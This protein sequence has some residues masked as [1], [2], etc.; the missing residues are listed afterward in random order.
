MFGTIRK[1]QTWLWAIIITLTIISFVIFFSPYSKLNPGQGPAR[2]G[3]IGGKKVTEEQFIQAQRESMLQ[4]FFMSGGRWPD[5]ESRQMGYDPERETYQWLFLLSK[6]E[7]MNIHIASD[8]VVQVAR[9]MI[10]QFQ[11]AGI[12]SPEAFRKQVLEPRGFSLNDFERF[13]RHYLGI[14]QLVA[15]FGASGKLITPDEAKTLWIRENQEVQAQAVFFSASN[16]LAQVNATPEAVAQY[17]SNRLAE[18][19]IPERVQV[20]YVE[21]GVSNFLAMA[22]AEL[23]KTNL[24]DFVNANFER[25]GTNYTRL[26][27]TPEE[28]KAKIR[29]E[30]I[31]NRALIEARRKANE[32]ANELFEKEPQKAENLEA[33]ATAKNLEAKTTEPFDRREGPKGLEVA[34]NFTSTAFA[35]NATNEVFGGPIVGQNGV[36]IISFLR[37]VPS[38]IP[39]L[40]QIRDKVA[41]DYKTSQAAALARAAG[42]TFQNKLT[43]SIAQGKEFGAV[44][45]ESSLKVVKLPPFSISTRSLAELSEHNVDLGALKEVVFALQPG[46]VSSFHP[47]MDGGYIVRLDSKLPLNETKLASELPKFTDY[48]RQNRQT[49]AFNEW[50]RKEAMVGL[51][52]TPLGQPRQTPSMTPAS[53]PTPAPKAKS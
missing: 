36:Y 34:Q 26:G 42:I 11:R 49:E 37:R 16:Y 30:L 33:L 21:F 31:K 28:A 23:T 12:T 4:Y 22:E 18:Y 51:R 14:Q 46:E 6:L 52:D 38:E 47:T 15:T 24:N 53:T 2:L 35:L 45:A 50:F 5:Q 48:L 39:S 41:N 43:N 8:M 13:V 19:R 40:D 25:L 3:S 32:F 9:N 20:K 1:H 10:G 29:E 44:A 17:Y 27:N 7:E